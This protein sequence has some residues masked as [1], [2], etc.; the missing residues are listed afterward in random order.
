MRQQQRLLAVPSIVCAT[1]VGLVFCSRVECSSGGTI[2]GD[3]APD[4]PEGEF[5][6]AEVD[7]YAQCGLDAG[8]D[9][10][11]LNACGTTYGALNPA[12]AAAF[13]TCVAK[14]QIPC[15]VDFLT[16][17]ESMCMQQALVN[18]TGD[19]VFS[20]LTSDYCNACGGGSNCATSFPEGSGFLA[21]LVADTIVT[22]VDKT[23]T[24]K[25][26]ASIAVCTK[27]FLTCEQNVVTAGFPADACGDG[28]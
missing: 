16:A 28:G 20:T 5:C 26:D 22:Q 13:V 11:S 12:V 19:T 3:A 10:T 18:M 1:F 25:S 7:Y 21:F 14:S 23:C 4:S 15:G 24:V 2:P 27:T 9:L 17:L 8:C 6:A